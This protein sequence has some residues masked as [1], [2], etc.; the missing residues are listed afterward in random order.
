MESRH[1]SELLCSD[2]CLTDNHCWRILAI[3]AL[4]TLRQKDHELKL[5]RLHNGFK[6]SLSCLG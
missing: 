4:R 5:V 1:P 3:I 6:D 2:M